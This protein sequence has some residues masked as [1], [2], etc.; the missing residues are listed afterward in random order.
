MYADAQGYAYFCSGGGDNPV[1]WKIDTGNFDGPS[2]TAPS[3]VN[4]VTMT[5]TCYDGVVRSLAGNKRFE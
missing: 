2:S 3:E 4:K 5:D 1:V